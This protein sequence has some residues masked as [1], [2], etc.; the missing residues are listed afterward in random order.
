VQI[1][2]ECGDSAALNPENNMHISR[3]L[4]AGALIATLGL[5]GCGTTGLFNSAPPAAPPTGGTTTP[6]PAVDPLVV[7]NWQAR[8]TLAQTTITSAEAALTTFCV[9]PG[10]PTFCSNSSDQA[11]ITAVE[12]DLNDGLQAMQ[13]GLAAYQ[14]GG[15]QAAWTAALGKFNTALTDYNATVAAFRSSRN[16][17][18]S[19]HQRRAGGDPSFAD[20]ITETQRLT[21][22]LK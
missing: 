1:V 4:L 14:A 15:G 20:S 13:D 22:A 19:R 12:S 9:V 5:A 16:N 7:A 2:F 11:K 18:V 3:F 21:I 6:A 17:K 10:A 8:I